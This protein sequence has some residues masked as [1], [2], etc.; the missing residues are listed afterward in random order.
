M[1]PLVGSWNYKLERVSSGAAPVVLQQKDSSTAPDMPTGGWAITFPVAWISAGPVAMVP[2]NIGTQNAW[3]GG[4]LYLLGADGAKVRQLG[5]ADC[6]SDIVSSAGFIPCTSG[7]YAVTVRDLA[8]NVIWTSHVD[9]FNA[10]GLRLSPD[11]QGLTDGTKVE[12]RTGGLVAMPQGFQVEG[13]LD[14]STVMGY[15]LSSNGLSRGDLSWVSIGDPGTV[16][17]LG[18]KGDFI[19]TLSS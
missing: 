4:P 6:D 18:F 3:W 17:D 15:V 14:N 2:A 19:G 10:L 7:Q 12:T 13:W 9:G 16:H 8:G 5:A 1:P 11:G